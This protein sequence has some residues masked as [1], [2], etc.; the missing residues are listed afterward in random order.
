MAL[1]D[2]G[3]LSTVLIEAKSAKARTEALYGIS[4]L[5]DS[6]YSSKVSF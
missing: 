5:A 1:C 2:L 6:K 3:S 4:Y